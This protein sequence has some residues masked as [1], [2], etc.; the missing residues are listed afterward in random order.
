L[1]QKRIADC[2]ESINTFV[3]C[4]GQC[5]SASVNVMTIQEMLG[6]LLR[7]GLSQRVIA[8]RVGTTQPTINRAAKGADVRYVTGKAIESLYVQELAAAGLKSAA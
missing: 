4:A 7:S 8:D 1:I 5:E 6:E 3:Y 2:I